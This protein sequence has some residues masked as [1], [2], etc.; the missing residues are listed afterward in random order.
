MSF[1]WSLRSGRAAEHP[2]KQVRTY[3][4]NTWQPFSVITNK[5]GPTD[6]SQQIYLSILLSPQ[7]FNSWTLFTF[8][9]KVIYNKPM[10]SILLSKCNLLQ[11]ALG[12]LKTPDLSIS[13]TEH[14]NKSLKCTISLCYILG[15]CLSKAPASQKHRL[16]H[17]SMVTLRGGE[18]IRRLKKGHWRC[19]L[20][21]DIAPFLFSSGPWT[22][23]GEQLPPSHTL[24]TIVF[25]AMTPQ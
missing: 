7:W 14:N 16:G 20:K 9:P 6:F 11:V 23:A 3:L 25:P 4:R 12:S 5:S 1:I 2:T 18:T 19:A 22:L 13:I 24:A 10:D 8:S 21:S 15:N 17:Q